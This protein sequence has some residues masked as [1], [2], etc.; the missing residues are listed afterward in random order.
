MRQPVRTSR[1]GLL[2]RIYDPLDRHMCGRFVD[3]DVGLCPQLCP[4]WRKDRR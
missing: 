3:R 1:L 2:T 4:G